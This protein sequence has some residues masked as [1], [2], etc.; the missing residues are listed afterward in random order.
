MHHPVGPTPRVVEID[1]LR[2]LALF[3]ILMVNIWFFADSSTVA[4]GPDTT[5]TPMADLIVR[6]L[7]ATFFEGKFYLLF[8]LLFGYG[9]VVLQG[10]G[11]QDPLRPVRR[12]LG[13]LAVLGV[14]HGV[15]LFYGDI[16][17][18]YALAGALLVATRGIPV[19]RALGVA[20]AITS[21][22][23]ILFI[24]AA[25]LLLVIGADGTSSATGTALPLTGGP[26]A[27]LAVNA[28]TYGIILPSVVLFQGPL[29][30]AA[31]YAGSAFA[32]SGVLRPDP[33]SEVVLRRVAFLILPVGLGV[34][35]LQAYLS[36]WAEGEAAALLATG[37]SVAASPLVTLGYASLLLL[38]VRTRA[39]GLLTGIL[40][41]AG[42]LSLSNYL[43]QS[44]L[45]CILFTGYGFGFM[46]K[47]PPTAVPGIVV[48]IF[49][50]QSA[51][52][53]LVLATGRTGPF[54]QALRWFVHRPGRRPGT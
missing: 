13:F 23:A 20:V 22:V 30:L 15:L 10:A 32:G 53:R 19:R 5:T 31:F 27:A 45:L 35:A 6:F 26:G 51:V 52:S 12:R 18:T 36:L 50:A 47:V 54:E 38:L 2:G 48:V 4:G 21:G 28:A 29:A 33:P 39:G 7:V 1:A 34:S 9:F 24:G 44:V 42:R 16:L 41:P 46:D 25:V 3:G 8:S 49:T 37:L 17:L 43:G 14:L 40:A 11:G